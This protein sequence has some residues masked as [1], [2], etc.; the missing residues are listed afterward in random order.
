[1]HQQN[2]WLRYW[3]INLKLIQCLSPIL[4]SSLLFPISTVAQ[5]TPDNSLGLN[6]SRVV[7]TT[8]N[9]IPADR[10]DGGLGVGKSQLHS[11][12]D[13]NV[14]SGRGAYFSTPSGK[15]VILVR[16]TGSNLSFINGKIGVL[17]DAD[18]F[19]LNPNGILFGQNASLDLNGSLIVSTAK[20]IKFSDGSTYG[21]SKLFEVPSPNATIIGLELELNPSSKDILVQGEGHNL[22][23]L[24]IDGLTPISGRNKF[25]GL[26]VKESKTLGLF[27]RNITLDGAILASPSGN[28]EIGSVENGT[29][30][31][32]KDQGKWF[33][34]YGKVNSFGDVKF[35]NSSF[36][37]SSGARENLINIYARNIVFK[38][39]SFVAIETTGNDKNISD[40]STSKIQLYA[41][42]SISIANTGQKNKTVPSG[43]LSNSLEVNKGAD[44]QISAQNLDVLIGGAISAFSFASGSGGDI[45]IRVNNLTLSDGAIIG[46]RTLNSG[47]G[48][49]IVIFANDNINLFGIPKFDS[50]TGIFDVVGSTLATVTTSPFSVSSGDLRVDA[51]SI[52]LS[53]GSNIGS[54]SVSPGNAGNVYINASDSI[55]VSGFIPGINFPSLIGS[56]SLF[57]GDSGNVSLKTKNLIVKDGGG[58]A[59]SAFD[60][61]NTGFL[62]IEASNSIHVSGKVS[63]SIFSFIR[64]SSVKLDPSL[65]NFIG[66]NGSPSGKATGLR[67]KTKS[68]FVEDGGEISALNQ[69]SSNAGSL[70]VRADHINI[71]NGSILA[72]TASGNG[73]NIRIFSK[74]LLLNNGDIS[75]SAEGKGLGGNINIDSGLL[76]MLGKSSITAN[77]EDAA[78]GNI[79]INTLGLF[80]SPDSQITATSLLGP[81]YDGNVEVIAEVTDFS[82]DPN[83]TIQTEPP[84]VY[85]ACNKVYRDTLAYYR[86]GTGGQPL[87]PDDKS[88]T[89]QGWLEA[90]NAR[91][92]QRHMSYIDPETGEK[93]PL[94]RVVGWKTNPDGTITFVSDPKE[95]DQ[96]AQEIATQQNSCSTDQA[97][98]G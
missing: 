41:S 19:F 74:L 89:S 33:S 23:T 84:Q 14:I 60:A 75:A 88:S 17:G 40:L 55:Q 38:D 3:Y 81:Q 59:V 26:Q 35:L 79:K 1:M 12:Q 44:I 80:R 93:K 13:F 65:K 92:A 86:M 87:S 18:L 78:A 43:I 29:I 16:I 94:E 15:N 31:I 54:I 25:V 10:I 52:K 91:Y 90:A 6:Q 64:A 53:D 34:S 73:G 8:I 67:I 28:I 20:N 66:V 68:L 85:S 77:A 83:L 97:N 51:R 82:Q 9:G 7:P 32:N 39:G 36:V 76:V 27:A 47:K 58:I 57:S 45:N 42:E 95:A 48:G 56:S 98:N 71:D 46:T 63:P 49:D 2:S 22:S 37:D 50:P 70:E 4:V 21:T 61:G 24:S 62:D 11:F 30:N 69:G 96:Y 5:I 72:T